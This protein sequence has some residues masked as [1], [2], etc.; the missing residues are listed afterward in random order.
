MQAEAKRLAE[1][2]ASKESY[3]TCLFN[4]AGELLLS[5]PNLCC[6]SLI[7]SPSSVA[8]PPTHRYHWSRFRVPREA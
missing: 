8:S 2:I 7:S 5:A 4:N 1:L 6:P 3:V